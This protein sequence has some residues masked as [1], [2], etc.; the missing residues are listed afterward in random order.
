MSTIQILFPAGT[1][2]IT[3]DVNVNLSIALG[4]TDVTENEKPE[5]LNLL[6]KAIV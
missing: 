6:S 5:L 4:R 1:P 2:P 3:V